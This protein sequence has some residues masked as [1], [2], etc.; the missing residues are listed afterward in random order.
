MYVEFYTTQGEYAG[1]VGIYFT[2]TPQYWLDYCS[3]FDTNFPSNLPSEVDKIW[4]I[5]LDRTAGIRLKIHCNGVEVLNILMSDNTC[6]DSVW[7]KY[8]SRDVENIY[9]YNTGDTAS[10]YYRAVQTGIS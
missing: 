8:W 3:S 7:R 9:F 10:D 4:R 1:A 2:S 6:D 5:S